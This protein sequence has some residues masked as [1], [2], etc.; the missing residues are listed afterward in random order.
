[1]IME[2]K[3]EALKGKY[4][5]QL[6]PFVGLVLHLGSNSAELLNPFPQHPEK[7]QREREKERKKKE[8]F[9]KKLSECHVAEKEE[10]VK[11]FDNGSS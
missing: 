9:G 4:M 8:H 7:D 3:S 10:K 11:L 2:D 1:M 5:L 6:L